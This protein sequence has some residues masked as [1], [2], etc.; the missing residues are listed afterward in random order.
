MYEGL[1]YS[2]EFDSESEPELSVFDS[3]LELSVDDPPLFSVPELLLLSVSVSGSSSSV[4]SVSVELSSVFV[5]PELLLDSDS[6]FS[7]DFSV[8]SLLFVFELL[9]EL[10]WF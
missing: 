3:S 8:S 7:S 5:E 2:P 1:V 10:F 4:A 6:V 9:F